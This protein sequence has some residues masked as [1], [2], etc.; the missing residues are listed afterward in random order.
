MLCLFIGVRYTGILHQIHQVIFLK[1]LGILPSKEWIQF[2]SHVFRVS[3]AGEKLR[4]FVAPQEEGL[5]EGEGKKLS[6][7]FHLGSVRLFN[8]MLRWLWLKMIHPQNGWEISRWPKFVVPKSQTNPCKFWD[9]TDGT[10]APCE[11]WARCEFAW[12]V[13]EAFVVNVSLR[14]KQLQECYGSDFCLVVWLLMLQL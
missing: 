13:E 12:E 10:L 14:L 4:A 11:A 8:V 2:G 6:S 1:R 3:K 9:F 5:E 7:L